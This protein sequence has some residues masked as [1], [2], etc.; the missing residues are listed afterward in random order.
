MLE[1][2]DRAVCVGEGGLE[3]GE[4]LRGRQASAFDGRPGRQFERRAAA[5]QGSADLALSVVEALPDPLPGAIGQPA[6]EGAAGGEDPKADGLLEEQPQSGGGQA[7]PPDLVGQPDAEGPAATGTR[8][9]I[10]AKDSPGAHRLFLGAALVKSVQE[11]VP[12][13]RAEPLAMWAARLL[14]PFRDHAP[15][16]ITAAKPCLL[17]HDVAPRRKN[18]DSTSATGRRGSGGVE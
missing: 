18:R 7:E 3:M 14:E 10:A 2:G 16:R 9:A 6:T 13:Q 12:N 11:T 5:T 15:F 8:V 1:V 4:D 17:A